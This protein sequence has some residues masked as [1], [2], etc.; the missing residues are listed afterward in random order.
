MLSFPFPPKARR[1][2]CPGCAGRDMQPD[3]LSAEGERRCRRLL[4]GATARLRARPAAAAVLVPLCS[5]R[6]VPALLYTLRS[7]RLSGSHK[8]DVR[9]TGWELLSL[10][11]GP[12]APEQG[13]SPLRA[14]VSASG[15]RVWGEPR[16]S[17]PP[18]EPDAAGAPVR[19]P[20]RTP[21]KRVPH[22]LGLGTPL[23]AVSASPKRQDPAPCRRLKGDSG[24]GAEEAGGMGLPGFW[25]R[26]RPRP[27]PRGSERHWGH[28]RQNMSSRASPL[29]L[30]FR[31]V[32]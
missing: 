32:D 10:L 30:S 23:G 20:R 18:T 4:A 28:H 26:S 2:P 25:P 5:V 11:G 13:A 8:G 6:G 12:E 16:R 9:Y 15:E 14:W 27:R 21:S 7:S 1:P 17:G 22:R 19:S 24:P 3:C 31:E 29:P